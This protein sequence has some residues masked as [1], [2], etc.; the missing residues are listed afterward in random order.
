[1]G[2]AAPPKRI[3]EK[4]HKLCASTVSRYQVFRAVLDRKPKV[5]PRLTRYIQVFRVNRYAERKR[6]RVVVLKH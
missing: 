5:A 6:L 4:L 3:G 1:M 2:Y